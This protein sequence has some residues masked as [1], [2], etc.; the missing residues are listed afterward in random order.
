M[1]AILCLEFP[2]VLE[3][4]QVEGASRCGPQTMPGH[5]GGAVAFAAPGVLPSLGAAWARQGG[6][7]CGGDGVRRK[8]AR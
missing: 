5:P 6:A 3:P 4:W 1:A 7:V 2:G 8:N